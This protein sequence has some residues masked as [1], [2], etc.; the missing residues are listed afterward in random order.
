MFFQLFVWAMKQ[1]KT[2]LTAR[3]VE[4]YPYLQFGT[5]GRMK[6]VGDEQSNLARN[7]VEPGPNWLKAPFCKL[8]L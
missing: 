6:L 5:L 7:L 8:A 2:L 3:Q 1:T 4:P